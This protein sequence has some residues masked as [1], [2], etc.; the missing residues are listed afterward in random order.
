MKILID[1][2]AAPVVVREY[3]LK[4]SKENNMEIYFINNYCHEIYDDYA[5]V[6]ITDTGR[7]SADFV[8]FQYTN[9]NDIVITND[10]G[11]AATCLSKG[12]T[13]ISFDGFLYTNE[14]IITLL[15]TRYINK[16]NRN[17]RQGKMLKA[18]D[19]KYSFMETLN[20]IVLKK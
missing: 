16:K 7:D 2:D 8:V 17:K 6:I 4:V 13:V 11:L 1:C 12:A 3:S 9:K 18:Y 15:E 10:Y 5:K 19:G 20:S 14:N